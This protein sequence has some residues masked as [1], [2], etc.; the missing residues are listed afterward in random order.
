MKP[1]DRKA[2]LAAYKERKSE[3]GIYALRCGATG[4]VWVGASPDLAK[5]QNRLRFTL[6][7]GINPQR[8]LQQAF[9]TH[10]EAGLAFEVLEKLKHEDDAYLRDLALSL[11]NC[12]DRRR[13]FHVFGRD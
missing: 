3:A 4:E 8:S 9:A 6:G 10:G 5:V 12:A 1:S 2:V 11:G 13:P 7:L